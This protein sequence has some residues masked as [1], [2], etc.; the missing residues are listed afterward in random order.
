MSDIRELVS[1]Y[2]TITNRPAATLSISE[3]LELKK[4]AEP[5]Q[6]AKPLYIENTKQYSSLDKPVERPVLDE[7]KE[8]PRIE[9]KEKNFIPIE[10]TTTADKHEKTVDSAPSAKSKQNNVSPAFLMMKQISG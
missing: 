4:Y 1:E 10:N 7:V 3:F 6:M 8:Q 5:S 9:H 2:C